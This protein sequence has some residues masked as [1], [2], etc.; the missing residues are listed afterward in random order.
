M[1]KGKGGRGEGKAE[2]EVTE[3]LRELATI[4]HSFRRQLDCMCR[5]MG[6]VESDKCERQTKADNYHNKTPKWHN[7]KLK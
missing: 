7:R 5:F 1:E 4:C 6:Q 2:T 3:K